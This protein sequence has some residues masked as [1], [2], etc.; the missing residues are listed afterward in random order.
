LKCSEASRNTSSV[1]F[2]S[3]GILFILPQIHP[4]SSA[5]R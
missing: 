1:V 2:W 4:D 3:V 5:G